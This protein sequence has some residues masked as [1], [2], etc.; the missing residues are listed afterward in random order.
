MSSKIPDRHGFWGADLTDPPKQA[1][2]MFRGATHRS[3]H[4]HSSS[5]LFRGQKVMTA[6]RSSAL[7]DIKRAPQ[8]N[9]SAHTRSRALTSPVTG[10]AG[11]DSASIIAGWRNRDGGHS[12]CSGIGSIPPWSA[13]PELDGQRMVR[14]PRRLGRELREGLQPRCGRRGRASAAMRDA[15]PPHLQETGPF[16]RIAG[17]RL[18]RRAEG[19]NRDHPPAAS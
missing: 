2:S 1:L 10:K 9:D 17:G 14:W 18:P 5:K 8:G 13:G 7:R 15:G 4:L 16:G 3:R 11:E 6:G 19:L 12:A